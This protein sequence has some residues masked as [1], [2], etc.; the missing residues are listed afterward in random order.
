[1]TN[2]RTRSLISTKVQRPRVGR[3]LVA[4]PRLLEQL[5][6]THSLTFIL[7]PAGYGKTTL[8]STWLDTCS[9]PGAWLSLDEHDNDLVV[10]IIG[11]TEALH[12]ILPAAVDNT[13]AVLNG[14]TLPPPEVL[15]R[16]L[17]NDMAIIQ[18]KFILVLDDYHL[19]HNAAIHDLLQELVTYP[20][21]ALHL[22]LASRLDP[23]LPMARLRVLN[24]VVELRAPELRLTQAE[25]ALFLREVMALSVDEQTVAQVVARTEGWPVGLRLAAL[26][27]R[28]QPVSDAFV[29]NRYVMDYLLAEVLAQLPISVQDFL[30][31]T[32]FLDQLSGPL[33][34]TVAGTT[35]RLPDGERV[36][37]WLDHADAF[38][39]S[40]DE[41]RQW[42]RCHHLFQQLLRDR[43]KEL[44]DT[45]DIAALRLRASAWFAANGYLDEALQQALAAHDWAAA[46]QVVTEHRHELMNRSQWQRLERWVHLFPREVMEE[47]PNLL[48]C[49]VALQVVRQQITEMPPLLDRVEALLARSSSERNEAMWGEVEARRSALCYW[50]GDGA[51]SL[52]VGLPALKKIPIDSWYLRGYLHVFL[53]ACYHI[54]GDLPQAYVMMYASDEP[55]QGRD[56]QMLLVSWAS[57]IHW[58]AA[59]LAGMA[60]AARRVLAM[61][62]QPPPVDSVF[63]AHYFLGMYDYQCNDLVAA[64]QQLLPL[65]MHPHTADATCF[66]QSAILLA[67][68][69]Q[70]QNRP[71]E[72]RH[73]VD[74][75]LTFALEI[76]GGPL[77]NAARAFQVELALRQGRLAEASQAAAQIEPFVPIPIP[78]AFVQSLVLPMILLAQDTPGSRQQVRRI[79]THMQDYYTSIHYT[80]IRIQ[81][82]ALQAMLYQAEGT[83]AQALA[84]LKQALALAEPGGF[85]RLFVDLGPQLKPLL[86]K[87]AQRGVSPA[88]L[89]AIG[90][91]Y[92]EADNPSVA[93]A[94]LEQPAPDPIRSA[95]SGP[96]GPLTYRE[97]DVL[98]LL[99]KRY[100]NKEIAATLS[101]SEGTVHTHVR[102]ISDKLGVHGRRAIVQA[103]KD[104]GLLA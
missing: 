95:A 63:W 5:N 74:S 88:Y 33:C 8:L 90:A 32:S 51:R 65:V 71:E 12:D 11:L 80:T 81:V 102:N 26:A 13:L 24:H 9:V 66:V 40:L 99:S 70:T 42:Y 94:P 87:L 58:P 76:G 86:V 35:D 2:S 79:L 10:F 38:V 3:G 100:S 78:F 104:Q 14:M 31:K 34:A 83:E 57:F 4:R 18:Q 1:M 30:I 54:S 101:I 73:I 39:T 37:D 48:L 15:T 98:L 53:A 46:V 64:E 52:S 49:E 92:G 89:A 103:A 60:R 23:P 96:I 55:G 85:L 21:P 22:V 50:I 82:L 16:T 75:M 29:S 28:R 84:A 47:Q 27:L 41:Q 77:L 59:D 56:L 44:Y 72:A 68:I 6:S 61:T 45:A 97:R 43:L 36:L 19:I 91:A 7:A 67:R 17:L 20:P 69:R 93:A 62:A 25:A